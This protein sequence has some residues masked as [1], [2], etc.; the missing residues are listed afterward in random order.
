MGKHA[1]PGY[2]RFTRELSSFSVRLLVAAVVFFGAV[3]LLI[4]YLPGWFDGGEESAQSSVPQSTSTT[5]VPSSVLGST[6]SSTFPTLPTTTTS[7]APA[8]T[9]TTA[10]PERAPA[11]VTVLVRNTTGKSGLAA[12][13]S[14]GLASLGY[15]TLEPDNTTPLL[16]ATQ[17]LFAQGFAAEAYTLA[18]QFPDGEVLA[19]PSADPLADIVVV[20]GTSYVP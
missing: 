7:T 15:Q 10:P 5:E 3:W 16:S 1:A 20:L 13:A 6:I 9:S 17:I 8:P 2:G 18:A 4:T 12:S 11:D 19:N 14:A